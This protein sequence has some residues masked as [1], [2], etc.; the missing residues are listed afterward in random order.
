MVAD[1]L[2]S[3]G[4]EDFVQAAW[5][6]TGLPPLPD[7]RALSSTDMD[8]DL[9][10]FLDNPSSFSPMDQEAADL[11]SEVT[12]PGMPAPPVRQAAEAEDWEEA[13][14]YPLQFGTITPLPPTMD[15]GVTPSGTQSLAV[16]PPAEAEA[17]PNLG[18]TLDDPHQLFTAAQTAAPINAGAASP[19]AR[20]FAAPVGIAAVLGPLS[21]ALPEPHLVCVVQGMRL[22]VT[23]LRERQTW[24][25]VSV[26]P[27]PTLSSRK[28]TSKTCHVCLQC[29]HVPSTEPS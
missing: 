23:L 1:F 3:F 4:A 28:V 5:E 12:S 18:G 25:P 9:D 14:F 17:L 6:L 27:S 10:G 13:V 24:E 22:L 2:R 11:D 8:S 19:C 16:R 26:F 20:V 15:T 29:L 7:C 21:A